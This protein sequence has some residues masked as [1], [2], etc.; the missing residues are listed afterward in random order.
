MKH[1]IKPHYGKG[2]DL[3]LALPLL[4]YVLL[5]AVFIAVMF[6]KLSPVAVREIFASPPIRDAFLRSLYTSVISTL[7]SLGIAIPSGYVLSRYR[8]PGWSIIDSLLDI[9][10]VLPPLIM[11]LCIL[12]FFARTSVGQF[13]DRGLA[14][15]LSQ[16][17][18]WIHPSGGLFIFNVGGIIVAQVVIGCAFAVRVI[19]SGFDA[20][21]P[22]Y[23]EV[24]MTLGANRRQTFTKIILPGVSP[25]LIAG[26]VI[27]WARIFG[28][29]GPILLICGTTR[30]RTEILPT[31]IYLEYSVGNL[32]GALVM[33]VVMIVI[34]ML[35]LL[36]FKRFAGDMEVWK[37]SRP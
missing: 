35:T 16:Y 10:I 4:A 24:A 22:R 20:L 34:S 5:L 17:L 14:A 29:F 11:G 15:W 7:I 31:S 33:G 37:C 6:M 2:F 36:I 30:F 21:D 9:P 13:L 23:E 26:A 12:L 19:K 28:L 8:F 18:H 3:L 1:S 25:S 27:S 32:D